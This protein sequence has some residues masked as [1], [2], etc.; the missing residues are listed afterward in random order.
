LAGQDAE[1]LVQEA[2]PSSLPI[3]RSLR[4][5]QAAGQWL[6]VILTNVWRDRAR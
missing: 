2:L 3:V 5:H 1:D 6:R 4:D